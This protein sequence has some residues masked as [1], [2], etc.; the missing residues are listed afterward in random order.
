MKKDENENKRVHWYEEFKAKNTNPDVAKVIE[1]LDS[2]WENETEEKINELED[3]IK[4]LK[5]SSDEKDKLNRRLRIMKN[6]TERIVTDS[7]GN[8]IKYLREGMSYS[9]KDL[10]AITGVSASYINRIEK[11]KRKAPSYPIIEKLASALEVDINMFLEVANMKAPNK[12]NVLPIGQLLL[13]NEFMI[14]GEI[15]TKG[16]V[17]NLIDII[18]FITNAKW[19]G[20]DK[21][22]E[23]FEL[24]AKIDRFKRGI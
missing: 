2:V 7:F 9:L 1:D 19:S 20:D 24:V 10:E 6:R 13:T 16:E 21:L 12:E 17:K 15:A 8:L 11:G 3:E 4:N 22:K 18:E 14:D 5:C 23:T